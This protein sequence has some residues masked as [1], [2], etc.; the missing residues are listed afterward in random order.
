MTEEK[1]P[2]A[3]GVI[4]N[5]ID[6]EGHKG[7]GSLLSKTIQNLLFTVFETKHLGRIKRSSG[8]RLSVIVLSNLLTQS[9]PAVVPQ[10]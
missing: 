9:M 8:L 2:A 5:V 6:A 4:N 7:T 1:Q 10:G 3:M